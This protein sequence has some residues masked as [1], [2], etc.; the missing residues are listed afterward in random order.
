M[1]GKTRILACLRRALLLRATTASVMHF[2]GMPYRLATNR[3]FV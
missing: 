2:E 3:V 1:I